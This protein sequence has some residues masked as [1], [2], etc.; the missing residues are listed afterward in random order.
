MKKQNLPNF[1]S[2]GYQTIER[3]GFNYQGGRATYQ[4]LKIDTQET[5][6]IK[7]FRFTTN[8]ADW[9]GYQAVE[10][11]IQVLKTL[12][13]PSIPRYLDAFDSGDGICLVQEHKLAQ[14]LSISR[15]LS[16]VEIQNIAVQ[17][18]KILIYLQQHN[19]HII[20]RDIKPENILIDEEL[21]VY[22]VDFGF[23]KVGS[24]EGIAMS[25]LVSGTPGFMAP[26]QLLNLPLTTATDLYGLGATLICLLTQTNSTELSKFI[27]S[28]FRFNLQ[29]LVPKISSDFLAWLEQMVE[30]SLEKRF[31]DAQAALTRLQNIEINHDLSSNE[32]R[33]LLNFKI[34]DLGHKITKN[35]VIKHTDLTANQLKAS[36]GNI[37]SWLSL[38]RQ[39]SSNNTTEY[40]VTVDTSQLM[41]NQV[42]ESQI[43]FDDNPELEPYFLDIK[44]DTLPSNQT[45]ISKRIFFWS[46]LFITSCSAGLA[47][48]IIL[49]INLLTATNILVILSCGLFLGLFIIFKFITPTNS[50]SPT[51]KVFID[52]D[53]LILD[54]SAQFQQQP[55]ITWLITAIGIALGITVKVSFWG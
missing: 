53:K 46:F 1:N 16:L 12:D 8:D 52:L 21:K 13:H 44:I 6:V 30:P 50:D 26:E 41:L 39:K 45:L 17:T 33:Q 42:Y 54:V 14:P 4:A 18:L 40:Q 19:P 20:H 35:I 27:D 48:A 34:P 55:L 37:P 32:N 43:I 5:V 28:S 2:Y 11:E 15:G 23:A 51:E 24:N 9:S 29:E 10:R 36:L 49:T 47:I 38:A 3:L 7:Q 25:S 31:T 22:L